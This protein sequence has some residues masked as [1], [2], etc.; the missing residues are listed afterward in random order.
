MASDET[1][2]GDKAAPPERVVSRRDLLALAFRSFFLQSSFNYERMQAGGW[3][4]SLMAVLKKI[5]REPK[6][7]AAAMKRHLEFFN[8]HPFLV[9]PILGIVAAMEESREKP[10]TIRG[11]KVGMMGPLGGIGDAVAWL[12]LLPITAG[13]GASIAMEGSFAGAIFFLL[14]FNAIHLVLR[15]G[16][17]FYGYNAGVKAIQRLKSGTQAIS[18]AASIVGLTVVGGMI[19]SY[20]KLSTPAKVPIGQES[21]E[22][23]KELLDKIMPNLLP[24]AYTLFMFFLLKRGYSPLKLI[25]ITV[26]LGVAGKYA[27]LL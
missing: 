4:Y 23:Q 22:I 26:V 15:F 27:G 11:I 19:V 10:D 7:L 3:L 25:A 21:F 9:T 12:T 20:V 17:V 1:F 18:R 6:A 13:I 8:T 14:A 2:Q 5:Y 24:L 16:G